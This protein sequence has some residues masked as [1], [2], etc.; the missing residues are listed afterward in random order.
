VNGFNQLTVEKRMTWIEFLLINCNSL[1]ILRTV[2][3]CPS[4]EKKTTDRGILGSKEKKSNGKEIS[5]HDIP[6]YLQRFTGV[7]LIYP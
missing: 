6:S 2:T 1:I 5:S 3:V 4:S 7:Q